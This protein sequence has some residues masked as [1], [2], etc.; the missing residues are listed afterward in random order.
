MQLEGV[1]F[2]QE[3]VR[4]FGSAMR[5]EDLLAHA[6]VDVYREENGSFLGYQRNPE[7]ARARAFARYLRT[8]SVPVVPTAVLLNAR[9]GFSVGNQ[10]GT[11]HADIRED[12]D[13]WVIDGQHRIEGFRYAIDELGLIRLKD[14]PIPVVIADG[15]THGAGGRAVPRHQ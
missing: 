14:F 7:R 10:N 6:Q 12:A 9:D 13:L 15:L 11:S 5:A 1:W 8:Q 4:F 2:N 3:G